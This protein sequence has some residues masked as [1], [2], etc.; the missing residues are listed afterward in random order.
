[1]V[2]VFLFSERA[3]FEGLA[4][5]IY[6]FPTKEAAIDWQIE[7][8]LD[9]GEIRDCGDNI[10]EDAHTESGDENGWGTEGKEDALELWQESA[11]GMEFFHIYDVEQSPNSVLR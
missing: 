3:A 2:G 8:L 11:N 1:M 10:Y 5:R 9:R 6:I 7:V 4:D